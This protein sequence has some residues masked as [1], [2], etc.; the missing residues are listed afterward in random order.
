MN[1]ESLIKGWCPG[2][3]RPMESGDGLLVRL[4]M[5]GGI[6]SALN[7]QIIAE[8]ARQYGNGLIDLSGRANLQ[9]RGVSGSQ[10]PH[11]IADLSRHGLLDDDAEA[12]AVRNVIASPLAGL[13]P[14]AHLDIRPIVKA[15]EHRLASNRAL[16]RLPGKFGF[17]VDDGGRFSLSEQM[18]DVAF[19]ATMENGKPVFEVRIGNHET[20]GRIDANDLCDTAST[21]A[22]AFIEA[23]EVADLPY[24]RMVKLV[25]A[26]GA[27]EIFKRARIE[28]LLVRSKRVTENASFGYHELVDSGFLGLGAPFGRLSANGLAALAD[29]ALKSGSGELRLTPWRAILLPGLNRSTAEALIGRVGESF[30]T[31]ANDP[32]LQIAACTGKPSCRN[33]TVN[34]HHDALG[35]AQLDWLTKRSGTR[36]HVSGC[37]KGCAH[38]AATEA[39]LVGRNGLYDLVLNGKASDGAIKSGL[40]AAMARRALEEIWAGE[41]N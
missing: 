34:T 10:W 11:L 13:D 1:A 4:R 19:E 16:H 35:F 14:S 6:V 7:A 23:S 39:V 17:S 38:P 37:E 26:F 12:E 29:F 33:A 40:D 36:L 25:S 8:A 2:A 31:H 24:K 20:V 41:V 30:I 9:I 18:A 32:R 15:L 5:T 27:N 22:L 3:L 28:R 21:L